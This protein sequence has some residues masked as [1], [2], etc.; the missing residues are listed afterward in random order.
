MLLVIAGRRRNML[1]FHCVFEGIMLTSVFERGL[2]PR[3]RMKFLTVQPAIYLSQMRKFE[4]S[5]P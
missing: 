3:R 5:F 1:H 2:I 4:Y